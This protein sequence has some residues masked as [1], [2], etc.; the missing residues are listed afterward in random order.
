ML[1]QCYNPLGDRQH[2]CGSALFLVGA[3]VGHNAIGS[4]KGFLG[5]TDICMP[6]CEVPVSILIRHHINRILQN[7]LDG[8]AGKVFA[9][10]GFDPA[11]QQFA[12]H[13]SLGVQFRVEVEDQLDNL[14]LLRNRNQLVRTLCFLDF[15]AANGFNLLK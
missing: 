9:S 2:L 8:K 13:R 14:C 1:A 5:K 3:V 12:F 4:V 10:L 6:L 11:T 7:V 15:D